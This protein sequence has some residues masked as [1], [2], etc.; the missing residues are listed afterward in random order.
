MPFELTKEQEDIQRAAREFAEKEFNLDLALE[1]ERAHKFPLDI[2]R[3]SAKL[4]FAGIN[5]P[6][7]YGGQGYG[8][9]E[10]VLVCEEF[11]RA[12]SEIGLNTGGP[13]LGAEIVLR[14]GNEE[15]KRKYLIPLISGETSPCATAFTEPD[16]GSD[17]TSLSTT[18][19]KEGDQYIINGEKTFITMVDIASFLCILCQTNPEAKPPYRGQSFILMD[20]MHTKGF[21]IMEIGEKMGWKMAQT[22]SISFDNVR[23][24]AKNLIGEE[25]KGF[26]YGI[27]YLDDARIWVGGAAVG[28]A[29]GAFERALAYAKERTQF[30]QK[31]ANFQVIQHK[32]VD[33][34][35]K[36][37][38]AR[39][40]VY[41]AAWE[42][43]QG[44]PDVKLSAMAKWYPS[45][46]A[47]EV[48]NEAIQIFGGYG[49][50]LEY[51]IERIFRNAR[52]LEIVEGTTEIQKNAIAH[53]LIGKLR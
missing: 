9:L 49:Y 23:L 13:G 37:E 22:L 18:A 30:G 48:A 21:E 38:T 29:Q 47:I 35:T 16:H 45:R 34:L 50:F 53:E 3:K 2:W 51:G 8:L 19:V 41:K 20:D 43:D 11:C 5:F 10:R 14:H 28:M 6:E 31:I 26:Y 17:I 12:D 1:L 32:L 39:L 44:R 4:G 7:E 46:V 42:H 15:Q 36:I 52:V 40:L 25:N 33:M 24:P 27:E